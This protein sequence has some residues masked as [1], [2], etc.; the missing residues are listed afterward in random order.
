MART[1]GW[2]S[3]DNARTSNNTLAALEGAS[4][5]FDPYSWTECPKRG[6]GKP[7]R[8]SE[9]TTSI[10]TEESHKNGKAS[11]Y[12]VLQQPAASASKTRPS[13]LRYHKAPN[14]QSL[15]NPCE[16]QAWLRQPARKAI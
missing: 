8:S 15:V 12:W 16:F 1:K 9:V 2:P 10:A 3:Y 5:I 4:S 6:S 14:A 7:K 13:L 11:A